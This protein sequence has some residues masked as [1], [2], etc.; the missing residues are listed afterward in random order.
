MATFYESQTFKR[1]PVDPSDAPV[2]PVD[3]ES[4]QIPALP[5]KADV[6]TQSDIVG[7]VANAPTQQV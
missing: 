2:V 4:L 1:A 6:P 5:N 7:P 3:E